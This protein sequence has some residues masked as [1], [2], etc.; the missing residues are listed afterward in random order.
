MTIIPQ[1]W[2]FPDEL[3]RKSKIISITVYKNGTLV[4]SHPDLK[5]AIHALTGNLIE[6]KEGRAAMRKFLEATGYEFQVIRD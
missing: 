1:S 4:S 2:A 5:A 3:L 6:S